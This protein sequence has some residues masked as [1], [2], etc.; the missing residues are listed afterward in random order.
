MQGFSLRALDIDYK[1]PRLGL[2]KT[3]FEEPMLLLSA[4]N[5]NSTTGDGVSREEVEE[6]LSFI[7]T[8][9]YPEGFSPIASET[10]AYR[11]Y[12][13]ALRDKEVAALP[14]HVHSL[15]SAQLAAQVKNKTPKK[16]GARPVEQS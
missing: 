13:S 3:C 11:E 2:D 15:S 9:V 8:S 6:V 1:Q 10:Q 7:Y 4:R 14:Q 12:C 16:V 5:R